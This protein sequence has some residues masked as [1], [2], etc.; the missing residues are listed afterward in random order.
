MQARRTQGRFRR[1]LLL[2][3]NIFYF[4]SVGQTGRMV[5]VKVDVWM[6]D[7]RLF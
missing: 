4:D 2:E 3:I 7:G 5:G 6:F 1:F